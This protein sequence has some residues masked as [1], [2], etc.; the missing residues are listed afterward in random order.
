MSLAMITAKSV[1]FWVGL[2][3]VGFFCRMETLGKML[4]LSRG[5]CNFA[6]IT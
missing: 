5:A 1:W 6:E 2:G 4:S 3:W